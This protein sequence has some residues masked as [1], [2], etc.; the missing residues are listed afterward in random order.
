MRYDR[1]GR[2]RRR[3]GLFTKFLIFLLV[4][5]G[6]AYF[7]YTSDKFER[8][9]PQIQMP[10]MV[11]AGMNKPLK[12]TFADGTGLRGY[13]AYFTN[14]TK[15]LIASSGEFDE[16]VKS[17]D[18]LIPFPD[19]VMDAK[20]N[21]KW[22]L[23]VVVNDTSLWNYLRGNE[24]IKSIAIVSDTK[25][26]VIEVVAK[27]S[28]LARGGSALIIYSAKDSGNVK[29]HILSNGIKFKVKP[30]KREGYYAGLIAWPF[31][32]KNMEIYIV[33]IDG[34]G[35]KSEKRVKFRPIRREYGVSSIT[36]SERFL[37][38]KI[39]EV[40]ELDEKASKVKGKINKFKAVNEGMRV[41]N[42]DLIHKYSK[43]FSESKAL[44]NWDIKPFYPL[45]SAKRVADFGSKRHYFYK[46]PKRVISKSYHVGYDLASVA[47]APLKSSNDGTVVFADYN[48]IYGNM[49]LIDHGFGLF[50]LYGHCTELLVEK[51]D[52]I[53][54]G[55]TIAKTGKSGL[56][57]GDHTHFGML[58]QGVE[59]WPME[60]MKKNWIKYNIKDVFKKADKL[61]GI[62]NAN[63]GTK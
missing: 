45:K 21:D 50:T 3:G 27:S 55:K 49:P 4:C 19:E 7:V 1:Y 25:P 60:W 53:K 2:R 44:E 51:G 58:I 52:R 33:A 5:A 35:N 28:N 37:T 48:G 12:V 6:A 16:P 11:Y 59:V 47:Q 61:M 17:V 9:A 39:V 10:E 62:D 38:G 34:A 57:L 18:I 43:V 22:V 29:T 30:Y 54:A 20:E 32:K 41:A 31:K 15:R 23:N 63:D 13:K 14:G 24:K 40:A 46:N 56:A 36:L 8:E 26:P 42:E